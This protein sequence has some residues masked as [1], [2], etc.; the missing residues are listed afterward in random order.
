MS[1]VVALVEKGGVMSLK[2]I[3]FLVLLALVVLLPVHY[4]G[5]CVLQ[6]MS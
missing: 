1:Q 4:P 3:S 2:E 5:Y 6:R